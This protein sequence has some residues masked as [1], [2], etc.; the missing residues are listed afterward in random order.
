MERKERLLVWDV[1]VRLFHFLLIFLIGFSY[2]TGTQGGI[3][4]EYHFLSGYCILTL[5]LFRI[6]WG[7]FGS[8]T[9]LFR[10]FVKTPRIAFMF[11][12]QLRRGTAPSY[13]THN[14]AGGY[15]VVTLLVVIL[16][17]TV[18]GLFSDDQIFNAGP[19]RNF[20]PAE[21]AGL[22]TDWH[23][24]NFDILLFLIV[25]HVLAVFWHE[26]FLGERLVLS[27]ITGRK[28]KTKGSEQL[29]FAPYSRLLIALILSIV[30]FWAL[31]NL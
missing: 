26:W 5:V 16:F 28:D 8:S 10:S 20:V 14:P 1:P 7:F 24:I 19:L 27:M 30:I 6:F 2:W 12:R 4:L 9:A 18:T 11:L 23:Q 29:C 17:Q 31:V 21:T 3:Y 25:I 15:M 13:T 22:L